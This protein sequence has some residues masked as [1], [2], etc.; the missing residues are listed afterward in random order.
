VATQKRLGELEK[1]NREL[2]NS[3]VQNLIAAVMTSYYD[4]VRQQSYLKT[5]ERSIDAS[6]QQL[7]IVQTSRQVGMANNADLFQAQIDLNALLQAQISQQLIIRPVQDRIA[8][9]IDPEARFDDR[10]K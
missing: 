1:Q 9:V 8:A 5:I 7:N 2:L 6:R 3:Q 10:G 4:V